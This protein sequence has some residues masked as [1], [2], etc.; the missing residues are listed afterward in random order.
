V[1]VQESVKITLA[2]LIL[3]SRLGDIGS[4]YLASPNLELES[5]SVIRRLRWPFAV[6]TILVFIIPWWDVGSGIVIMVASFLVAASNSSKLW[7][8]RA[9]G[10][11]EYRALLVRM[12][13]GARLLPS[14]IFSLMP[15]LFMSILGGTIMYLYPS[16]TTDPGYHIGLGV[17]GYA[18]VVAWYGPLTFLRY[19]KAG[20]TQQGQMSRQ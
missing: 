10:E 20:L 14:L 18:L 6:L 4:T 11:S 1:E 13:A 16:E 17:V 8:I 12:A 5:N 3:L 19:R 7:L 2:V 9:M 15:A